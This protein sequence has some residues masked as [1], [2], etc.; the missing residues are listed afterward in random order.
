MKRMTD[1]EKEILIARA[2]GLLD[3]VEAC[4]HFIVSSIKEKKEYQK[5]A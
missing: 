4:L 1:K 5:A 2:H 3:E